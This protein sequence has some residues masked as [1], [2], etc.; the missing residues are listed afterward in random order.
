MV[1]AYGREEIMN[2]AGHIGLDGF[3]IK[4]VSPS[5]IAGQHHG[6]FGKGEAGQASVVVKAGEE[7]PGLEGIQGASLLLVEDNEINQQVAQEI[8]EGAGLKVSLANHGQEGVDALKSANY[9]AVLMDVQMPVMD[10]YSATRA[11][12]EDSQ[13]DDL[14]IIAM[15][16]NAMAGDREKALEAGMNDHVAKPIDPAQLFSALVQWIKPGVR[17]FTPRTAPAAPA[18]PATPAS[19]AEDLL[20][21]SIPG[22]DIEAGLNRVAGNRKLY[23][24][25]MLKLR[26]EYAKSR[27]EIDELLAKG[28][29]EEAERAAH[30]IKGVAGNVGATGLQAASAELELAIKNGQD[31]DIPE[32][33]D[34][35][36]GE[37]DALVSALKVLGNEPGAEDSPAAAGPEASSEDMCA[38][39][40][41]L[42]PHLK[43]KKPKPCKAAMEKISQ[44]NWPTQFNLDIS[45]MAKL[46]KKYKFKDAV[47]LAEQMLQ[48]LKG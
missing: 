12:R 8:L 32:I 45:E 39:L 48:R 31:G 25:I 34:K 38:A 43:T 15:T 22:V 5:I 46:I 19:P 6:A 3:L 18:V 1:T 42:L 37:L 24:K 33:L 23:R 26:D 35:F 7:V 41:E 40:L 11:I 30:S 47:P 17:G 36:G 21:P 44:L 16:A 14:P 20:P 2:Q 27:T 28:R 9:H 29:L 4:P 13:F 10:G